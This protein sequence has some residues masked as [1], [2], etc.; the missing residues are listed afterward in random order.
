M[1][2]E[3]VRPC[4]ADGQSCSR[5]RLCIEAKLFAELLPVFAPE[6]A[7]LSAL[8][9]MA[10]ALGM[11]RGRDGSVAPRCPSPSGW[12]SSGPSYCCVL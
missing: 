6:L 4:C 9:A 7:V 3:G 1:G 10:E 11:Q 2:A 5:G 8:T 12:V